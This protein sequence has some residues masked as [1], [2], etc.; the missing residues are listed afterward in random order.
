MASRRWTPV[1]NAAVLLVA[2]VS[3][4]LPGGVTLSVCLRTNT[5]QVHGIGQ[6]VCGGCGT[7]AV[8]ET[9][10]APCCGGEPDA[11]AAVPEN[12]DCRCCLELAS[13]SKQPARP[14]P[15]NDTSFNPARTTSPM[16]H[17]LHR[18]TGSAVAIQSTVLPPPGGSFVS[19]LL[20]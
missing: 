15:D 16:D 20:I 11:G 6:D 13:V 17:G 9:V 1:A 10:H 19:P 12:D 14:L 18:A 4:G 3:L 2:L 8:T 7:S 5:L